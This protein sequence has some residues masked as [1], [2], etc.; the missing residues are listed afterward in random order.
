LTL[1]IPAPAQDKL[2]ITGLAHPDLVPF[3]AMM[4]KFVRD[5][6]VPGAALAVARDG[7]L[8]YARG[9]GYADRGKRLPV[10]PKARFRIASISKPITAVAILH[11]IEQ[12][13]LKLDD[14]VFDRLDLAPPPG[15]KRD[16]RLKNVTVRQLLQHTG[17]WDRDLS[18]D[19]MFRPILIA[20]E[21][22][23]KPP[24]G[25]AQV[26]RYMLGEPLDFDPGRRYAYSNF[27]YCVL[28]R[29]IEKVT[30]KT[31][32]TYVRQEI[33]APLGIR[34]MQIGKTLETAPGEVHYYDEKGRTAPAVVGP[35]LGKPVPTPYGAWYLEAMD[36]HGGWIASA[37]DLVRFAAAFDHPERCKILKPASIRTMFARPAGQAGFAK[38][39]KPLD[40]YY[41]CGWSIV[42]EN[43]SCTNTWHAGSLD[44]TA[45]I[46]VRRCD[47]L[48]WVVL[49]NTLNDPR[50][51][52]L[53]GLVDGLVHEAANRVQRW[54]ARDLFVLPPTAP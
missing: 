25:P 42:V 21:L 50:G 17:G 27:G 3:D 34:D 29:L 15:R 9:F 28:G 7:K 16:P 30:D 41:A 20:E 45:T 49:F 47:G 23:T 52:S 38:D 6:K 18:F 24:A 22:G 5:H 26:I 8:V 39:G 1:C 14:R 32:E 19:P 35:N 10:Q 2:P 53:T 43:P 51:E 31:Y 36:A 48:T 37:P 54:P 13:K 33:L 44:G 40:S 12:G 4:T 46:L 11:L